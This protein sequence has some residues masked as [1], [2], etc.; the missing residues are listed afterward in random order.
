VNQLGIFD[1]PAAATA[2][3][4]KTPVVL[5]SGAVKGC[6]TIYA[7]KGQ[8][9]EYAKLASNL[10]RGCGHE[11]V[12]CLDGDTLIQMADGR[13]VAIRD[14]AVGDQVLGIVGIGEGKRSWGTRIETTSVL[15]KTVSIRHAYRVTTDDGT[16]VVCSGDH[17]WLTE[18]GWKYT[19]EGDEQRPH[20]TTNNSIRKLGGAFL[21]PQE[22][23]DYMA[24]YVAGMVEGDANL[25][26]YD[27]SDKKRP[28]GKTVGVQYR[29]R[30]ALKDDVALQR[31]KRYL[32]EFGIEVNDAAFNNG[33]GGP[34]S[35]IQ[36]TSPGRYSA[37][38]NLLE[39]RDTDEWNRGW[40]AGVFDAEGSN[41]K[42]ALRIS[43]S[44]EHILSLTESAFNMLGFD[45]IRDVEK[46]NGVTSVRLLGGRGEMVRF[47][48]M[49][50]PVISRKFSLEGRALYGSTRVVSIEPM[51]ESI[52]MYDIMTGTE[53]FIANGL[54]SHNC[55]VP[56]VLKMKR[57]EFDAGATPRPNIIEKLRKDAKKYQAAGITDQVLL[58]FTTD[59][60]NH[61]D[62][63]HKL[64]RQAIQ[65][66][67]EY[68]L[69]VVTLTK[70][71][72]RAL[73]DIDLFRPGIDSFATTLT[74]LD[75]AISL[76]WEGGAA[77][78][79]D[80]I[81]T[82]KEFHNRGI[83]TWVS[84][85]PVYYTEATLE[86][87]RQTHMFV[88]LFKVGRINYHMLTKKTDWQQF[89]N[90]VLALMPQVSSDF[91]IKEDLR[92]YLPADFFTSKGSE[93]SR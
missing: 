4:V 69:A 13:A 86:I 92:P 15:A 42:E 84:M 79:Q 85:E 64:T 11:C 77:L 1:V 37:I 16:E 56:L 46:E 72:A 41:G 91:Y 2:T 32:S 26:I 81:N 54:V 30:L 70:G 66:L 83:H 82:L 48:Q 65:I 63:K 3:A 31:T 35:A 59:P 75:D 73:R 10:Y 71:G 44:D 7:P 53:N 40:L 52:E 8:A 39:P 21:T 89:T 57:P 88:D 33:S 55:Y 74:S 78:P 43:N 6:D 76:K 61:D 20:L 45:C 36:T 12:Y 25:A 19:V 34:M 58:S 9:G 87:I 29:F 23:E 60:Y 14:I 47:W 24:G 22:T 5:E 28:S 50:N 80:R 90:E 49:V 68:G 38:Q 93:S 18:R 17:R 27:Y 62:V 51:N 67:Q